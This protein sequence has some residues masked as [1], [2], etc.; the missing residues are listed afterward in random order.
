[1]SAAIKSGNR[2]ADAVKGNFLFTE[3]SFA[4]EDLLRLKI[5]PPCGPQ[6][7]RS[8]LVLRSHT[9]A[10][11]Q[12]TLTPLSQPGPHFLCHPKFLLRCNEINELHGS[13]GRPAC[14]DAQAPRKK[15]LPAGLGLESRQSGHRRGYKNQAN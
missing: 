2:A 14:P 10:R 13:A 7:A 5:P 4:N 15:R 9:L 3:F 11:T 6:T 1:M 8:F 12:D